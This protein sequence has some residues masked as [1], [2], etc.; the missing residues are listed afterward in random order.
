MENTPILINVT[1]S[2]VHVFWLMVLMFAIV[3]T[4]RGWA[5]EMLV[6]FSVLT[7]IA[8]NYLLQRF[9]SD[10]LAVL[11]DTGSTSLFW[12]RFIILLVLVFFGY[13]TVNIS[14]FAPRVRREKI[15][16]AVLGFI[17]GAVN[18]YGVIGTIWY[19]L[20]EASYPFSFFTIVVS[21]NPNADSVIAPYIKVLPP[22][23]IG[24]PGIYFAVILALIFV[25]A[26]F[27]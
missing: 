21:I 11:G 10:A 16:D 17:F 23:L 2:I 4:M 25:L 15:Q 27:L 1:L 19:Y 26:V 22:Q 20:H 13:Q 5:K 6:A 14:K 7:A 12:I 24:E 3:G 18:G 9:G 8:L